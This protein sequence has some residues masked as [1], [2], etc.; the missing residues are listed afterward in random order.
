MSIGQYG[1]R[2]PWP[3]CCPR[4]IRWRHCL[5]LGDNWYSMLSPGRSSTYS[6]DDTCWH[7]RYA[8]CLIHPHHHHHR[9][10]PYLFFKKP[11]L[12][13]WRCTLVPC[14]ITFF[15]SKACNYTLA[16]NF[17]KCRLICASLSP[18][19]F[20]I[21][22]VITGDPTTPETCHYTASWYIMIRDL[23]CFEIR[24]DFESN[25]RFGIRFVVMIRFEIFESS[26]PSIV[27]CK[28]TIGGG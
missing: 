25:F 28:E 19:Y 12:F 2:I 5:T 23:Q 20:T 15:E 10:C 21:I 3:W 17:I 4:H 27:L 14:T 18:S 8:Q 9:R 16:C 6:P 26:A 13:S 24:F 1:P 7:A 11:V 22:E